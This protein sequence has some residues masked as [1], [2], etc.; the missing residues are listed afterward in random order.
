VSW[1]CSPISNGCIRKLHHHAKIEPNTI[2]S[3]A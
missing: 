3:P 1:S 2:D